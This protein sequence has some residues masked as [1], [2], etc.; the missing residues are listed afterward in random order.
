M[1]WR[2]LSPRIQSTL[3]VEG[4][5]RLA[6]W[7]GIG[8]RRVLLPVLLLSSLLWS[9]LPG[10]REASAADPMLDAGRWRTYAGGDEILALGGPPGATGQLWSG[11]EGGGLTVWDLGR[12][13]FEQY[14]FPQQPGLLSN[15]VHDLAF[16]ARANAWLATSEGVSRVPVGLGGSW[17]SFGVNEGLPDVMVTSIAVDAAGA[18]WAGTP[19]GV[20]V[21][22]VGASDFREVAAVDLDPSATEPLDGPGAGHVQDIAAGAD[23]KVY[24]AHGRGKLT[25]VKVSPSSDP[26]PALS[27]YDPSRGGWR[28]IAAADPLA[29]DPSGPPSDK[30]MRLSMAPDGRLW[31]GTWSRGVVVWDGDAEWRGFR[32]RDG[33]CEDYVWALTALAG[34]TW[35]A[36]GE[37]SG[38]GAY[39]ARWDGQAWETF[40]ADQSWPSAVLTS[41]AEVGGQVYAG[42]NGSGLEDGI[43]GAGIIPVDAAGQARPSLRSSGPAPAANDITAMLFTDDGTLWAGTFEQG[44]LRRDPGQ[45]RFWHQYTYDNTGG[46]LAGDTI[47]GLALRQAPDGT[48]ELWVTAAKDRYDGTLKDY[49]EGGVSR[50]NLRTWSWDLTLRSRDEPELG[51]ANLGSVAVGADRRVWMGTGTGLRKLGANPNSG[52]G[53]L[54]YEPET[55]VWETLRQQGDRDDALA[56]NTVPAMTARGAVLWMANSYSDAFSAD[57]SREGGGVTMADAAGLV[58]WRGGQGGLLTLVGTDTREKDLTGDVV[59]IAIDGDGMAWAGTYQGAVTELTEK[60]PLMDAV[61]NRQV[62]AQGQVWEQPTWDGA[63]GSGWVSALLADSRGRMWAGTSRGHFAEQEAMREVSPSGD[64]K[65]DSAVGG[66]A[67]WDEAARDWIELTPWTSGLAGNAITAFAVDPTTGYMWVGLED[68]GFSVLEDGLPWQ[69]TVTPGPTATPVTATPRPTVAD[70]TATPGP[71]QTP[72]GTQDSGPAMRT[73]AA[74]G[75]DDEDDGPEPPPEVPEPAT[76]LLMAIGLGAA[77]AMIGMRR[78]QAQA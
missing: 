20:A 9:L 28:H 46:K 26:Q 30:I 2:S 47:T 73:V 31:M 13:T 51:D 55:G 41:F 25:A 78:R 4:R 11:T 64:W 19:E 40:D 38:R 45:P 15:V 36:C 74:P 29:S 61:V 43:G 34:E 67:V 32:K 42:A 21:L 24:L 56:G 71:E 18:V 22:D 7:R 66:A 33:L 57:Q 44:L 77:G 6:A 12:G 58:S 37:N 65:V 52:R 76:W 75:G 3:A 48:P 60:F 53:V 59:S 63:A 54:V 14:L 23:G 1:N 70:V 10:R 68:G 16:D 62:A 5:S 8:P 39:L 50:L 27:V 49:V 69:P 17:Q 35:A 72:G